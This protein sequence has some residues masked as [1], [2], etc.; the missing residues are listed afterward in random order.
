MEKW[1]R[2]EDM[3][4]QALKLEEQNMKAKYRL[5]EALIGQKLIGQA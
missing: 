1:T 5:G 2:A 4:K 3:A